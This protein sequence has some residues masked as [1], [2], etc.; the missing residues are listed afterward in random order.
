MKLGPALGSSRSMIETIIGSAAAFC[1]TISYIPQ[2]RKCWATGET[3]D[4]SLK[5]LTFLAAGLA[6]WVCYGI[7]M[8]D[9][10]IVIA[11]L[12]SLSLVAVVLSF[13]LRETGVRQAAPN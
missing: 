11:N 4:L 10:V 8:S 9:W 5:M 1:T 6:L 3:T 7:L 12:I 13:K 2:V